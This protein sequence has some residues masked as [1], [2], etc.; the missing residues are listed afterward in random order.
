[1][2]NFTRFACRILLILLP[3]GSF[4]NTIIVKGI[5]KYSNGQ[6]VANKQ[7]TISLDSSTAAGC[8]Q[9]KT[10]KTNPNGY[11]IDTIHCNHNI[12]RI[13]VSIENCD[14]KLL[15]NYPQVNSAN[16]YAES[17]FTLCV[18]GTNIPPVSCKAHLSHEK[19]QG[20]TFRFTSKNS[21]TADDDSIVVRKWIFG[22]G[23][24][25]EGKEISA[26]KEFKDTG[27][28]NVCLLI[29]TKKGCES[30][31]CI[32]VTV[33]DSLLQPI[34]CKAVLSYEKLQGKTFRFTS[35][36]SITATGDSILLRKWIFGD[37]SMLEGKEISPLKEFKDTGVYN[38]CLLIKT[39]KG[40]ESKTCITVVVRDS[41]SIQ[42]V[43]CQAKFTARIE[44]LK[45]VFISSSTVMNT[46]SIVKYSWVLGDGKVVDTKV[47]ELHYQYQRAGKYQVC[48]YTKTAKGCESKYCTTIEVTEPLNC[49]AVYSFERT[50]TRSFRFNSSKSIATNG[51]SIK[52]RIWIFGDGSS[53]DGNEINP[54]KNF[55]DTG[56]YTV[57]LKIKSAKGCEAMYCSRIVVKDSLNTTPPLYCKAIFSF[58]RK[59][60][61]IQF[62]SLA[63]VVP[64]G[65]SIISR[66]WYFG[67][68]S[69]PLTGNRKD[70]YYQ[71][72][73]AGVY[74]VCLVIK[75]SKGCE[76]KYCATVQFQPANTQCAARFTDER[77]TQ[78]KIRF[79]SSTSLAI[80][81]D[82]II[83][84]K[85]KFGDG[86]ELNGNVVVPEKEYR[87]K[88]IYTVC[89]QI[90]TAAG[91]KSEICK[92]LEIKDSS[93]HETISQRIKIIQINPN[94]VVSRFVTTIW[95]KMGIEVEVGIY[96]IYGNLKW[97]S[98]KGL[99][100]GNN[101]IEIPAVELKTGPYFLRVTS[102]I[103]NDSRLFYK[104]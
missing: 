30:K 63:S 80:P 71:Y 52:Q 5:V 90:K 11:Y 13:K 74:N 64:Q 14:G 40:C 43:Q 79:N 18:P 81:G 89:L 31:T 6:P 49:T 16:S 78:K 83:E 47:K 28:Y 19:L 24:M 10:V 92:V 98:K 77:L 23:S 65:D 32:T 91:C 62:N 2:E 3:I 7:V 51:D 58:T 34:A 67:D 102:A 12:T 104:L 35:K 9:Y 1:M 99:L 97:K 75:T 101:F 66:S 94:P 17:N 45:T 95:T 41:G 37:G 4:A 86:T 48:L 57:C 100:S 20:R 25:L 69:A 55:K 21:I 84:R 59:E 73:K 72:R 50:G 46:D 93:A 54:L 96:D 53:I 61:T 36:N 26:L 27:V 22:D 88:G 85:W 60:Q 76:S 33:R 39:K 56:T 103:G 8:Y 82:S 44:G 29:K 68:S 87:Q 15:I 70:P 38:V 42:P